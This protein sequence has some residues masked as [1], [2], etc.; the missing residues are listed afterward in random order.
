MCLMLKG[1]LPVVE[2]AAIRSTLMPP[3][4]ATIERLPA[5]VEMMKAMEAKALDR[6]EGYRPRGRRALADRST[7]IALG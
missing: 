4:S 1:V 3:R 6:G 7:L 2:S 5:A